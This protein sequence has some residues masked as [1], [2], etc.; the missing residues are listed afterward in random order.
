MKP[1]LFLEF[2]KK[3]I[4]GK[5]EV[6]GVFLIPDTI[7]DEY[8]LTFDIHNPNDKSYS[9]QCLIGHA[10][11]SIRIFSNFVSFDLVDV[12]IEINCKPYYINKDLETRISNS[13]ERVNKLTIPKFGVTIHVEHR[14]FR[15]EFN[16]GSDVFRITNC[17]KPIMVTE[18][19]ERTKTL[20]LESAIYIYLEWQNK[21]KYDETDISYSEIDEILDDEKAFIDSGW[22]V[23]YVTTKFLK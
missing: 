10:D 3:F 9:K 1:K 5:L 2:Y 4:K 18:E 15:A 20:S 17:V 7:S 12:E 22:I 11:E 8:L 14:Y 16:S 19:F 21:S 23:Q 6:G 13:L